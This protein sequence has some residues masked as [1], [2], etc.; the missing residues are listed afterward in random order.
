MRFEAS[1]LAAQ[2]EQWLGYR[3]PS[4]VVTFAALG[5]LFL[6]FQLF[7]LA[8]WVLGPHFVPTDPGPDPISESKLRLF[9]IMQIVVPLAAAAMSWKL[10]FGPWFRTG[11]ITTDGRILFSAAMVFFWDMSLN[12]SSI[13]LFYNAHLV[14]F[15]AWANG[16]WP[17]W[18]SPSGHRLPEP[19]VFIM[20]A[21][22]ALV[23]SQALIVCWLL[24]MAKARWPSMGLGA[25]LL[26]IVVGL[27]IIDSIVEI[28]VLRTGFYAYPGSIGSLTLWAGQTYQFPLTE[29]FLFGGLGVGSCA[30]IW[31]FRDDKGRTFVERGIDAL[32]Y[33]DF[34]KSW[35]QTLAVYGFIHTA[36]FVLYFIPCQFVTLNADSFPQGYPSYMTNGM[37]VYGVHQD[38]CPGPGVMMPRPPFE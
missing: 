8:S 33:S 7:V 17:G 14:N 35:L 20:P 28:T 31:Y 1:L 9:A 11:R 5:S 4:L 12:Y 24:R 36:F 25:T 18:Y 27:T 23:F 15:G 37:C 16:A 26:A 3:V 13:A 2:R 32:R 34:T 6:A 10:L 19:I 38:Q 29:G 30:V 21:Y 22:L